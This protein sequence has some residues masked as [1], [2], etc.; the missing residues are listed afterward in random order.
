MASWIYDSTFNG[1]LRLLFE[2]ANFREEPESIEAEGEK[3]SFLFPPRA[4]G[5]DEKLAGAVGGVLR[6]RITAR[7][8][9]RGYYAFLSS[10]ENREM[11]VYTY[12]RLA[13]ELGAEADGM[14]TDPR[15]APVHEAS[16][17]VLR[18]RHRFLGLLRF[19]EI[20]DIL[21]A[22]FEPEGNILPLIAGHF[23]ARLGREKWIIHDTRRGK[24]AV[25][26]PRRWR[27]ADFLLPEEITLSR[28]EEALRELWRQYF[29]SI[30]VRSRE[31]PKLQRQFMPKK[32]WK[33][34]PEKQPPPS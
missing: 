28:K 12:Y 26:T 14:L 13:W 25:Y 32:Y 33:H 4:V 8:F 2:T 10:L 23:S 7:L 31:N 6:R 21:Y 15:V 11:A 5:T 27:I 20:G 9:A 18:E 24:A 19:M 17:A 3:Q 30:A 22:P 34:L 1:F 29:H 16:R